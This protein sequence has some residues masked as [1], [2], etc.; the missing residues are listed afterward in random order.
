MLSEL[1]KKK[2]LLKC[3]FFLMQNVNSL[4]TC[5][6]FLFRGITLYVD[7]KNENIFDVTYR[8]FFSFVLF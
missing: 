4:P 3:L 5:K 8:R 2:L 6:S 1:D 7:L